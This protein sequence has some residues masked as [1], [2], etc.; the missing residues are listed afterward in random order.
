MDGDMYIYLGRC[1]RVDIIQHERRRERLGVTVAA[2][3]EELESM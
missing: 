3:G 1:L 2:G